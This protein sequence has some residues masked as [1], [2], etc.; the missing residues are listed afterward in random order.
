LTQLVKFLNL[1]YIT[2]FK[3]RPFKRNAIIVENIPLKNGVNLRSTMVY[4]NMKSRL[5]FFGNFRQCEKIKLE[6]ITPSVPIDKTVVEKSTT[7]LTA[8]PSE[9]IKPKPIQKNLSQPI[10]NKEY[11]TNDLQEMPAEKLDE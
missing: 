7:T 2:L 6:D 8:T 3:A 1:D 11:A 4:V 5:I 9:Q 10:L